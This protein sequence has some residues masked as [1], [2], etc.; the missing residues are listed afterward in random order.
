M[1]YII[2]TSMDHKH[3]RGEIIAVNNTLLISDQFVAACF[4]YCM[5][6]ERIL[7]QFIDV[8]IIFVIVSD[9]ELGVQEK[10]PWWPTMGSVALAWLT[11]QRLEVIIE[12]EICGRSIKT[13]FHDT[14]LANIEVVDYA[15]A[16]CNIVAYTWQYANIVT[17]CWKRQLV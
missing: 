16:E 4:L 15:A 5:V 13:S 7:A 11:M 14:Q 17:G 6:Y 9:M 8:L 2:T 10:S 3:A 12:D 1:V